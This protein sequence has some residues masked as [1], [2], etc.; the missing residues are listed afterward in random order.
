MSEPQIPVKYIGP[1]AY[2]EGML[3]NVRLRFDSGQTRPLPQSLAL[4]YL[5]HSDTFARDEAH[6]IVPK[7]PEQETKEALESAAQTQKAHEEQTQEL[8][9]VLDRVDLMQKEQLAELALRYGTKLDR[10]KG[11]EAL[12]GDVKQLVNLNGLI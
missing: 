11:V 1:R 8:Y 7:S 9:D 5:T 10:R 4:K 2:W 6:Q 12:R 3:Y